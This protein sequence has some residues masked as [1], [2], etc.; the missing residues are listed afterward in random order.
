[1]ITSGRNFSSWITPSCCILGLTVFIY[2]FTCV[3]VQDNGS[4]SSTASSQLS[5]SVD[6]IKYVCLRVKT[7]TIQ[8][9]HYFLGGIGN[10]VWISWLAVWSTVFWCLATLMRKASVLSV[11]YVV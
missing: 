10:E 8:L 7:I 4:F 11:V 1:M 6:W 9:L 3:S 2:Q 5:A